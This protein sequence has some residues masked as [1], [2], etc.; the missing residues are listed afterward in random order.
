M[1]LKGFQA[2][3]FI[4]FANKESPRYTKQEVKLIAHIQNLDCED[5]LNEETSEAVYQLYARAT[6]NKE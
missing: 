3:Q 1:R 6:E 5:I 4:E 2:K